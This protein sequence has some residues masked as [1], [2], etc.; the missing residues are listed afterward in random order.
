MN[1]LDRG[2]QR[3][4][5]Q[6]VLP[7]IPEG[8]RVLDVGCFDDRLFR[9]LGPRLGRGLGLDPL[10]PSPVE[11]DRFRIV[12]GTFPDTAVPEA[13]FDVITML[14]VLEHAPQGEVDEW[15]EACAALLV[16]GGLVVATV[17]SPRVDAILGVLLRL[18]ILDGMEKGLA[19]QHHG[20]DPEDTTAAFERAGFTLVRRKRFQLGLNNL[21]VLRSRGGR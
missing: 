13:P 17:P 14:A 18:R 10:F 5:I 12:P 20:F 11:G 2:L 16:P 3:W 1:V 19:E 21:F 8:A 4:R 7:W 9:A 6:R 15:A